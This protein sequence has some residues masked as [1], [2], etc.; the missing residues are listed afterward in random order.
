M[1]RAPL[2]AL[3]LAA[4]SAAASPRTAPTSHTVEESDGT[5]TLVV[6]AVIAAPVAEVWQAVSTPEGWTGWAAPVARAVGE[7]LLETSYDKAAPVGG[8]QTIRQ[9]I[10]ARIPDRLL[11]FRTVKAPE[12]FP[13][14]DTYAKVV[15]VIELV[16]QGGRHT[17]VRLTGTRYADSEAG[18]RLLAFFDRG[19]RLTLGRLQRRF[20]QGPT[21]WDQ[22][23]TGQ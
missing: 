19:N 22:L 2:L 11:V 9:H 14:F 21:E 12:G 10:L 13:D 17:L 5:R 18:R 20:A 4:A 23:S 15:S 7:D 1:I 8:P 3:L 6:E 16:P